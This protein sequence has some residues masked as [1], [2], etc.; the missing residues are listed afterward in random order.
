MPSVEA[1]GVE[2]AGKIEE[3]L[4]AAVGGP[5]GDEI[6]HRLTAHPLDRGERIADGGFAGLLIMLDRERD[7]GAVDVR[8]Q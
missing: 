3:I 8:R 7:L 4:E 1:L 5:L 6:A 2:T